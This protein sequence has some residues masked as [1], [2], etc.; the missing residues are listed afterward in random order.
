MCHSFFLN[1][2][3]KGAMIYFLFNAAAPS[4]SS[5]PIPDL[6]AASLRYTVCPSSA[7]WLLHVL[8]EPDLQTDQCIRSNALSQSHTD[9]KFIA[10]LQLVFN[11]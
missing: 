11:G 5:Q 8:S 6:S 2:D 9:R 4:Q 3:P 1:A 10:R 7:I